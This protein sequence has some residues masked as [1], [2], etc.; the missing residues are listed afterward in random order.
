MEA[1]DGQDALDDAARHRP[2]ALPDVITVDAQMPRRD[3]WW[4]V[5]MIRTDP[6]LEPHPGRDGHRLGPAAP[7]RR[8]PSRPAS[9]ASSPSRS[10]PDE[11]LALI[12]SWPSAAG[13]G[14]EPDRRDAP[15]SLALSPGDPR[16]ALGRDPGRPG[17]SPSTPVTSPSPCPRRSGSSGRATAST[18]TGRPT[19]PCSWPRRPAAAARGRRRCSPPRLRRGRRAS[20]AS[21]SPARASSTS[22]STPPRAGELA[23][24]IV[25]AGRGLRAHRRRAPGTGSTSSS[26]RP[27]RPARCTSAA[28]AGPPSATRS[29]RLLA[30]Q[31]RRG[32]ARVL[33]Q[34]PRRA[35][36][37][38]RALAAGRA[39]Q[40]EPAPEDGYAGAYIDDIAA[41]GARAE[42]G[43]ARRCPTTRRRRSS[44]ATAST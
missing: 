3:G 15:R 12:G 10:S 35:D 2:S 17:E 37:P 9:T 38:V 4:A 26:S 27:T 31:R 39:P 34:R 40:G 24:T 13:S 30:G 19:S 8:R 44:G 22:P 20:R 42:P 18:A 21:T 32:H 7:P 29:R 28:P 23:R 14:P 36:R 41:A 11:L 25:E 5:A 6:R 33:L 16:T 1:S 43:P